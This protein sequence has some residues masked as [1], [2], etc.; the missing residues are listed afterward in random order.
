MVVKSDAGA[1]IKDGGVR[2]AVEVCGHN[3]SKEEVY[4]SVCKKK[5]K[6]DTEKIIFYDYFLVRICSYDYIFNKTPE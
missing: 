4:I 3:L 5:K 6:P 1:S 2:V